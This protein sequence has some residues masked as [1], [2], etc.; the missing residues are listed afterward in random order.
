MKYY[1]II[2]YHLITI[3]FIILFE[4]CSKENASIVSFIKDGE[5]IYATRVDSIKTFAGKDRIRITMALPPNK[6]AVKAVILWDNNKQSK[7]IPINQT[8]KTADVILDN[9]PESSYLFNIYTIDNTGHK[10]VPLIASGIS[11]GAIYQSTLLNRLVTSTTVQRNPSKFTINWSGSNQNEQNTTLSYIN[12]AG[13]VKSIIVL[14]TETQSIIE[15]IKIGSTVYIQS[16]YL[17]EKNAIDIFS[18]IKKDELLVDTRPGNYTAVGTRD[19]YNADGSAASSTTIAIDKQLDR[20]VTPGIVT[21]DD[22]ANLANFADSKMTLTFNADN[23]IDV[24]GF[25]SK[26]API[27]N[28][29]TLPKSTYDPATGKLFLRYKYTNPDGAYRLIDEV[30]SP[31]Y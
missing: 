29:P 7:E 31:K 25:I 19:N 13:T 10:S 9:M 18:T 4:G 23:T 17:P 15:N 6:T 8:D 2:R 12:N 30:L 1:T 20:T 21:T 14:T 28:H 26:T 16:N 3:I 22:I 5:I 24:S 27:V 11:Y